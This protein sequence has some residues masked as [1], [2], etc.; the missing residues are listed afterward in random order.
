M[1]TFLTN[2][3][4]YPTNV[5]FTNTTTNFNFTNTTNTTNFT[6]NTNYANF[7][8][9]RRSWPQPSPCQMVEMI[10]SFLNPPHRGQ[11]PPIYPT[12]NFSEEFVPTTPYWMTTAVST[13]KNTD[14]KINITTN[15]TSPPPRPRPR[16]PFTPEKACILYKAYCVQRIHA[17]RLNATLGGLGLM[18][19]FLNMF[20]IIRILMDNLSRAHHSKIYFFSMAFADL[21]F[22]FCSVL[23]TLRYFEILVPKE[24]SIDKIFGDW[25]STSV[26]LTFYSS[27]FHVVAITVDRF[28]A[29]TYPLIHKVHVN[30]P[31]VVFLVVIVWLLAL[32]LA[33]I[34]LREPSSTFPSWFSAVL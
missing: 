7:T 32:I 18:A 21:Y 11:S 29:T 10:C 9:T 1:M 30:R 34:P 20:V 25:W 15:T 19:F 27:L 17:D 22:G 2:N 6:L 28:M 23:H 5:S 12:T 33:L 4:T 3:W 16:L 26:T 8:T 24:K 14:S 13:T 31:K